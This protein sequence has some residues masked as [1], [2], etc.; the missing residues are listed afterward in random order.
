MPTMQGYYFFNTA[1]YILILFIMVASAGSE[2][3]ARDVP[4]ELSITK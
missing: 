3:A 4:G 2:R 1:R